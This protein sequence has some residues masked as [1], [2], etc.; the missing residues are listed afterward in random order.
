MALEMALSLF[1]MLRESGR[2]TIKGNLFMLPFLFTFLNA[3]FGLLAVVNTLEH[4][5]M[6]AACSILLAACMDFCD[7]RLARAFGSC[8][9]LGMEL[10][11]LCDAVS[12]CFAPA[13]LLYGW[14]LHEYGVIGLFAVSA[15]LCAG[16]F[17]LAKFNVQHM[18][19]RPYFV[20]LPTTF[21]AFF[22]T[23]LLLASQWISQ[24]HVH[25]LVQAKGLLMTAVLLA[26]LMPSSIKFSSFKQ[27]KINR[28]WLLVGVMAVVVF[29]CMGYPVLFLSALA[30][31]IGN[32]GMHVGQSLLSNHKL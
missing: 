16:L 32:I 24:S 11:S 29:A 18:N 31:M 4:Y 19:Q 1:K 3:F 7:G 20:G 9:V 14:R 13:I 2:K 30:Y 12:F 25:M 8:S 15:Y 5:Y 23:Q 27:Y 17:R 6:L 26:F 21:A 28:I 22:I 10:D